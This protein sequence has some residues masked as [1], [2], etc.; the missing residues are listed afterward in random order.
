[1]SGFS[2]P[3]RLHAALASLRVRG[4]R[5]MW[6]VAL[7]ELTMGAPGEVPREA[8]L[9]HCTLLHCTD[10]WCCPGAEGSWTVYF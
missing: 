2:C 5:W 3:R 8:T 6:S 4:R 7:R 1:M 9:L 10:V